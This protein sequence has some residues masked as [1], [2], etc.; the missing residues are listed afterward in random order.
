MTV[1]VS[2]KVPRA[3]F[4]GFFMSRA[5]VVQ[6]LH[7]IDPDRIAYFVSVASK[8]FSSQA[9]RSN[10]MQ[11]L[12]YFSQREV[13]ATNVQA[14]LP[15]GKST[16]LNPRP[17]CGLPRLEVPPE[18]ANRVHDNAATMRANCCSALIRTLT[19]PDFDALV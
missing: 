9:D 15:T 4:L 16:V 17:Y 5:A 6:L 3:S 18:Y 1:L 13:R 8:G 12:N 19:S 14:W 2:E 11:W 10:G 7:S